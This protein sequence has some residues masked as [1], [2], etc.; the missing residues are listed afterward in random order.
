MK[1]K[2][3]E[4]NVKLKEIQR[5]MTHLAEKETD[6]VSKWYTLKSKYQET[7][8]PAERNRIRIERNLLRESIRKAD[9]RIEELSDEFERCVFWERVHQAT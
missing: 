5:V 4:S 9:Q 7:T 8:S 2:L 6:L 1:S 3:T